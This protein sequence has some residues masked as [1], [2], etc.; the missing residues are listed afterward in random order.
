MQKRLSG[1]HNLIETTMLGKSRA[2]YIQSLGQKKVRDSEG[3]FI[4]E[5]PKIIDELL[6]SAKSHLQEIYA[7]SS[8]IE[9]AS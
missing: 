4:A 6:I 5:G 7:V 3:M 2:K 8:W 1:Y 9:S